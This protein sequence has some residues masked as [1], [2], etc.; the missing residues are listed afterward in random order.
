MPTLQPVSMAL[1]R[2]VLGATGASP[3]IFRTLVESVVTETK[4]RR[5]KFDSGSLILSSGFLPGGAAMAPAADS[6]GESMPVLAL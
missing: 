4:L 1:R 2:I 6:Q 5:F 3:A